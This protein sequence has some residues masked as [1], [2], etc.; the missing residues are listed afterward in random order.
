MSDDHTLAVYDAGEAEAEGKM[1]KWDV[2]AE[3]E[4]DYVVDLV[5]VGGEMCVVTGWNG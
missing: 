5:E 1:V 2:R 4:A 3:V